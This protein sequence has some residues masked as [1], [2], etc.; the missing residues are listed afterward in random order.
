VKQIEKPAGRRDRPDTVARRR[1]C[2][3]VRPTRGVAPGLIGATLMVGFL[4]GVLPAGAQTATGAR[5]PWAVPAL[6][7]LAPIGASEFAA[8]RR[9]LM[10]ELGDGVLLAL[11]APAPAADYLPFQQDSRFR[12]LT[13]VTEPS[14]ALLSL[15]RGSTREEILFVRTRD[16]SRELW[17]GSRLGV[18]GA[19]QLTGVRAEP[20]DRL[21]PVL[22]SL[23]RSRRAPL[24]IL[25]AAPDSI[26]PDQNL[27]FE[28]QFLARLVQRHPSLDITNAIPQ[29]T[30]IRAVKSQAELDRIRRAGYISAIGH[31]EA[32]RAAAD[33]MN[34]FEIRA[35]LEYTFLRNGAT[36]PAYESIVGS[37]PNSTTL[38]YNASDRFFG[39]GEVLLM[40]V[41][42][43]YDGYAADVTRTIPLSGRFTTE[44]RAIYEI[45]LAAQKAAEARLR[46]GATW[47]ELNEAAATEISRG[48]ARLG[49][50][51]SPEA[52]YQ[53]GGS[54][55]ARCSQARIFYM[56]GLGHGVGLDV[57]DPDISTFEGFAPGSAVTIEPGIYVRADAFDH[58]PDTPENRAMAARLSAALQTYRDI[59]VRIEDVFVTDENGTERV[60]RGAPREIDEIEALMREPDPTAAT[61]RPEIVDWLR[62]RQRRPVS[63]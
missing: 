31:R 28:A 30:R 58:I 27:S 44:Q 26:A 49:L 51:D 63:E 29:L 18:E 59:G 16:P 41:G 17:E 36:G 6:P 39:R 60:S 19:R 32:M 52:T 5:T 10:D 23:L 38:H 61:R 57:H 11:G 13:G 55:N 34:E 40:D 25:T 9:A 15:R 42:A 4:A 1:T 14:A 45:V 43:S 47:R 21:V 50:I 12:W 48:L 24:Y 53:C 54:A 35:V 46:P 20:F 62:D 37:G 22:D 2:A 3:A 33:G 8:R 56:H 7:P